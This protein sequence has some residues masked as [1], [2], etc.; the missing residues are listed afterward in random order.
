MYRPALYSSCVA[1]FYRKRLHQPNGDRRKRDLHAFQV[2]VG[3]GRLLAPPPPPHAIRRPA[4]C[5]LPVPPPCSH[6]Q[7]LVIFRKSGWKGGR[8][9]SRDPKVMQLNSDSF[10]DSVQTWMEVIGHLW[11]KLGFWFFSEK[12]VKMSAAAD[13]WRAQTFWQ[14]VPVQQAEP[15]RQRRRPYKLS[16][17]VSRFHLGTAWR[18]GN[19]FWERSIAG[20]RR[21]QSGDSAEPK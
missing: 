20:L 1:L 8:P 2:Y 6:G 19:S 15:V 5:T 11:A 16:G 4:L 14:F 12:R 13:I 9:L 21:T 7:K 10:C 18:R 17:S 3:Q